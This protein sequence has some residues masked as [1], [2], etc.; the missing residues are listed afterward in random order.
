MLIYLKKIA[1]DILPSVVA[2]VIGAYI[3]NHYITAKPATNVPVAAASSA[4]TKQA[5]LV[6]L[7]KTHGHPD[8]AA[9][10]AGNRRELGVRAKGISENKEKM[11][12]ERPARVKIRAIVSGR[13]PGDTRPHTVTCRRSS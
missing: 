11:A 7:R 13:M 2:T 3:V 8:M 5:D 6:A 1:T 4:E 12:A 9:T 10:T